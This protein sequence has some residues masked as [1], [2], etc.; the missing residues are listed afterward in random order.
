VRG[1]S[2]GGWSGRRRGGWDEPVMADAAS[3]PSPPNPPAEV[4][5]RQPT[6]SPATQ[7]PLAGAPG[8]QNQS[9][10]HS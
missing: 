2:G 7:T 3:A 10:S 8:G 1:R 5:E 4:A 9:D 6:E